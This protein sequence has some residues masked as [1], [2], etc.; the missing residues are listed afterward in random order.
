MTFSKTT[1]SSDTSTPLASGR[2]R[3]AGGFWV[4]RFTTNRVAKCDVLSRAE[5]AGFLEHPANEPEPATARL[6]SAVGL[7]AGP[8]TDG[9]RVHASIGTTVKLWNALDLRSATEGWQ[10]R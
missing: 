7:F 6:P 10:A 1:E 5:A 4:N 8:R 9:G 2:Q 3:E